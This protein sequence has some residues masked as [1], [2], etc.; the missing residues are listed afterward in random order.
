MKLYDLIDVNDKDMNVEVVF[1]KGAKRHHTAAGFNEYLENSL[2][3]EELASEVI[4]IS[5]GNPNAEKF[6]DSHYLRVLAKLPK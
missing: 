1:C 4:S 6:G 3:K 2:S 5:I